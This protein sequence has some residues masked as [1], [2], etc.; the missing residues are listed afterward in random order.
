MMETSSHFRSLSA[1][2]ILSFI[3]VVV[4]TATIIGLPAIWLIRDQLDHQIGSQVAQ[5]SKAA[6]ALCQARQTEAENLAMLTAQRPTLHELLIQEDWSRLAE[7]LQTLQAGAG[8]DL[9]AVCNANQIV[10]ISPKITLSESL[11]K[12]LSIGGYHHINHEDSSQIWFTAS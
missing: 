11:C 10:G 3:V 2:L 12:N 6:R 8:L 4:L 7:Y 9:I 1:Q 5:G